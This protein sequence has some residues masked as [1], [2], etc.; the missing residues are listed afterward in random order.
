MR[1]GLLGS[2][3]VE[4]AEGTPRR[5]GTPKARA[6]LAVLLLRG[7]S[8]VSWDTVKT[9]IWGESVPATARASLHNHVARLRR[10]LDE[11][12]DRIQVTPAGFR[13]RVLD[14]EL[15][16]TRFDRYLWAGQG[17]RAWPRTGRRSRR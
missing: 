11:S 8:P 4:D 5:I 12:G 7:D 13:L 14:D 10:D 15:D 6:L 3:V 9:A 17:R 16:V 2:F 1:F